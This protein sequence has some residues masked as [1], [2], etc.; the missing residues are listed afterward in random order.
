MHIRHRR[1]SV[2]IGVALG[3]LLVGTA[4]AYAAA[5]SYYDQQVE[6]GTR[7][8]GATLVADASASGGGAVKFTSAV[9]GVPPVPSY[10]WQI[11]AANTGLAR[12]GL[13]CDSLPAY[14]GSY[15]PAAGTSITGVRL[16][17]PLDLSN[18]NITIDKSC[19]QPTSV[20]QGMPVVTTTDYS[21][22]CRVAPAEVTISN[23]EFD[24]TKLPTVKARAQT[25]GF[26]GIATLRNNYIHDFGSGMA[27]FNA[28]TSLSSVIEGNYVTKLVAWGD[29]A[30]DGNHSDGFTVRDFNASTTPSR[31]LMVRGNRIDCDSG[32]DSGAFFIQTYGGNIRNVTAQDNL[33][34]GGG[35]QLVLGGGFGNSYSNMRAINNRFSGTGYGAGYVAYDQGSGWTEQRDNYINNPAKPDNK[36]T[37]VAF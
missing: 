32:N 6:A 16:V 8:G 5:N 9:D 28:G 22:C 19:I 3:S 7:A 20:G 33:L 12:Y 29:P 21:L 11:T 10:G 24:G 15:K 30:G 36:G 17:N 23:S 37:A 35:Y 14:N 4:I 34:E 31:T 25:I 13:L 1:I 18:G 26:M 27:I 2:G